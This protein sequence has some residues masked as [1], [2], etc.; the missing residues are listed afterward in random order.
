MKTSKRKTGKKSRNRKK[1]SWA[2]PVHRVM[3]LSLVTCGDG[4]DEYEL[5]EVSFSDCDPEINLSQIEKLFIAKP[6]AAD[7]ADWTALSE[8]TTRLSQTSTDVDA[9]RQYVVIGDKPLPESTPKVISG[10]RTVPVD[11]KHT[12]NFDIDESNAI[13][14][15]AIRKHKCIV[16]VKF[17]YQTKSGHLFGGNAGIE[18]SMTVDMVLG[19]ADGDIIL[20]PGN[21]KWDSQ[22]LEERTLSPIA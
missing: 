11:K 5:P 14:H 15:E 1:L 8:W 17:W 12:I 10:G 3:I 7:F 4:C 6:T 20:Y 19:R 2:N 13:N 18:A 16:K 9:I 21:L 22:D